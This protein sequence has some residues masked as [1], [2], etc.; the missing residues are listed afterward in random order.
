MRCLV[1]GSDG[2]VG[3]SFCSYLAGKGNE[4][5][6]CDIKRGPSEDARKIVLPLNRVDEVYFLAWDVGGAKYLYRTDTQLDQL[7][8]NLALM[9]NVFQQLREY[10]IPFLFVSSQLAEDRGT[11]YGATKRLGQIWTGLLPRGVCVRLWNV[12]GAYEDS[13]VRSHVVAD[14]VHQALD[15]GEIQMLTRGDERRQFVH[16]DDV[17]RG[18][19]AALSQGV[20]QV[21]DVSR[22]E[23]IRVIDVASL[24]G[25]LTGARVVPGVRT[26]STVIIDNVDPVPG[27]KAEVDLREGLSRMIAEFRRRKACPSQTG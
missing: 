13:T 7:E 6:R 27:W 16:I 3:Q 8:W 5:I 24:I 20:R 26:G 15:T 12:Y 14:F 10:E 25:E 9:Q 19:H 11:V 18:F 2:F 22:F 1:I 4:V 17:C 21:C 23:W